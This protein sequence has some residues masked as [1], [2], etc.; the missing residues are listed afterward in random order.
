[1]AEIIKRYFEISGNQSQENHECWL[2][3]V[4]RHG[5]GKSTLLKT[6]YESSTD[7]FKLE[8]AKSTFGYESAVIQYNMDTYVHIIEVNDSSSNN[9]VLVDLLKQH[10]ENSAISVVFDSRDL[11][12]VQK[13]IDDLLIPFFEGPL[14]EFDQKLS[15]Q[16]SN[17][18]QTLWSD[19]PI[20][21]GKGVLSMNAGVP[22]FFIVSH[23]DEFES[24]D[25]VKFDSH[26]RFIREPGLTYAAGIGLSNSKSL[27]SVIVSCILRTTLTKE[28]REKIGNRTDYFLPPGWDSPVRLENIEKIKLSNDKKDDIITEIKK[29]QEWQEFLTDLQKVQQIQAS[30]SPT[31]ATPSAT[32]VK[33]SE[34]PAESEDFL[35]QFE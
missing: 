23:V 19:E 13:D 29:A 5:S 24:Y 33:A 6:F 18:L 32:P 1:M 34:P 2:F 4:G 15:I 10:P 16:Y 21:L 11:C 7:S 20:S 22:I 30:P 8:P 28:L 26:M 35:S 25:D 9:K 3:V 31:K 12:N 27:I 14:S 17:F